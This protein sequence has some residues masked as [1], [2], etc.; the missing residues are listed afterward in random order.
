MPELRSWM[1]DEG[2]HVQQLGARFYWPELGRFITQDPI[3][4]G[5][6]W[7]GYWYANPLR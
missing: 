7:Y 2:S 6:N 1:Q 4:D 5:M 3:G